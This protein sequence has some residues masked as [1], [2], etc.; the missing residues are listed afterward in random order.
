[1]NMPIL[2]ERDGHRTW[3]KWHR[4]RRRAADTAF[5][6]ERIIEAMCL[7]ASI[8]VDLVIHAGH[9]CAVLHDLTLERETTGAGR[10]RNTS[11][12]ALRQLVEAEC[13]A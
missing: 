11:A 10:V 3:L 7:G 5:T 4:G 9:G 12:A 2:L 1:M 6:G 13:G 8:E